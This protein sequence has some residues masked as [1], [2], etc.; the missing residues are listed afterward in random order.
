MT[1][2]ELIGLIDSWDEY[3]RAQ[4][5]LHLYRLGMRLEHAEIT[6]QK[7]KDSK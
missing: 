5:Y 6:V 2:D 4:I 7:L 1:N 3:T